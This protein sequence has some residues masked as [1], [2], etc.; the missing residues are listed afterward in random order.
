VYGTIFHKCKMISVRPALFQL[1][2]LA[3]PGL[4]LPAYGVFD[5]PDV[6]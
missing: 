4:V 2:G 5:T 6:L 3:W 1:A